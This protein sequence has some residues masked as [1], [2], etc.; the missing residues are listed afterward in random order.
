MHEDARGCPSILGLRPR[1]ELRPRPAGQ[2]EGHLLRAPALPDEGEEGL[3]LAP[4]PPHRRMLCGATGSPTHHCGRK[5]FRRTREQ[6]VGSP[7]TDPVGQSGHPDSTPAVLM[8]GVSRP[9]PGFFQILQRVG[10]HMMNHQPGGPGGTRTGLPLSADPVTGPVSAWT[11]ST[12]PSRN[13]LS[14][15]ARIEFKFS[16]TWPCQVGK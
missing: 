12:Y 8:I 7:E 5:D 3:V 1:G 6:V 9:L 14:I 13:R 4:R 10:L 2:P 11:C 16:V 15:I